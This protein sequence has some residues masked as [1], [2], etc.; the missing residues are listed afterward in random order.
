MSEVQSAPVEAAAPA[1]SAASG[2]VQNP[3]HPGSMDEALSEMDKVLGL[4]ASFTAQMTERNATQPPQQQHLNLIAHVQEIV[5]LLADQSAAATALLKA[6]RQQQLRFEEQQKQVHDMKL[7]L[8]QAAVQLDSQPAALIA[9]QEEVK[10]LEAKTQE[11]EAAR[12]A[13]QDQLDHRE[14]AL[15]QQQADLEHVKTELEEEKEAHAAELFALQRHIEQQTAVLQKLQLAAGRGSKQ[16]ALSDQPS[17]LVRH[18]SGSRRGARA[19][20]RDHAPAPAPAP[21]H[22]S[23]QAA[24]PPAAGLAGPDAATAAGAS[25]GAGASGP[26]QPPEHRAAEHT[27]VQPAAA[28]PRSECG[29]GWVGP[30]VAAGMVPA[31]SAASAELPPAVGAGTGTDDGEDADQMD[32][33]EDGNEGAPAAGNEL[34]GHLP[35]G[36]GAPGSS[37]RPQGP[38]KFHIQSISWEQ[39]QSLFHLQRDEAAQKLGI[40]SSTLKRICREHGVRFLGCL[41]DASACWVVGNSLAAAWCDH[42]CGRGRQAAVHTVAAWDRCLLPLT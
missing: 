20:T 36:G 3:S 1:A 5:T 34:H 37:S 15:Q 7:L 9:A 4:V 2:N 31:V 29:I 16:L 27:G 17:S 21:V 22:T 25:P 23:T 26:A 28:R 33:D 24:A 35:A 42:T 14:A 30:A 41:A 10:R 18:G 11:L 8:A 13:A 32:E 6:A 12:Q 19:A 39:V 38:L 40:A